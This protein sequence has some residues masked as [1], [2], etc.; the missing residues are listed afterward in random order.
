MASG[1]RVYL[2]STLSRALYDRIKRDEELKTFDKSQWYRVDMTQVNPEHSALFLPLSADS[3]TE[4]FLA[5]CHEKSDWLF[6]QLWHTLVK[7]ILTLFMT[8]TSVN[9]L[10]R[11]GS[12]FV[13]SR[14]QFVRLLGVSSSWR[15]DRLLDLGAGDGRV[16]E[17]MAGHFGRVSATE[18]SGT[19]QSIL[20]DKGY[21]VLDVATWHESETLYDVVTCLN[22]LDRCDRPLTLLRQMRRV[23]RPD[24]LLVVALV[25]PLSP[26]VE[27][28]E[29]RNHRPVEEMSPG[30]STFSGQISGVIDTVFRPAGLEVVRWSRLPYLCEGDLEQAFYW[31]SDAVFVLRPVSD[32]AEEAPTGSCPEEGGSEGGCS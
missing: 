2:R 15:A 18:V 5:Q 13:F 29:N 1:E 12:M 17:V 23:L 6:T 7:S 4:E 21:S 10:L 22:V 8:Q 9:G 3:Q 28:G 20:R 14:E 31:L 25:L 27:H 24:G 16:T 26:Y 32:G 19:M 30:G 11:R